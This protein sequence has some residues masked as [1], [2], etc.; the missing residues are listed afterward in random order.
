MSVRQPYRSGSFYEAGP[1]TCR[2]DAQRLL[3]TARVPD[4]L[5]AGIVGGIVPHAGWVYS[6][7][8]AAT[9]LKALDIEHTPEAVVLFGADHFGTASAGEVYDRGAWATPL[10]E[11]A[12]DE[13]L[14]ADI[15]AAGASLT[16]NCPA[17]AQ[18]HSLEVQAPLIQ[19][20]WPQAKLV[21]I[22]VS[23]SA[24]AVE[25]GRCVAGVVKARGGDIVIIGSTDLTHHGGQFGSPGG[26]GKEGVEWTAANDRRMI[27][28]M[29]SMS[30][31]QIVGEAHQRGN[32][33]GAGAI[34]ATI[35]ACSALGATAGWSLAYTNS[36]EVMQALYPGH[37]DDTTVGYAS[38]VFA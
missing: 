22:L 8:V 27:E 33:C 34:A 24:D 28:L 32:A 1:E 2:R 35:A 9:T 3:L 5:P 19:I 16:A 7:L 30:A 31:E 14:A 4:D 20:L 13:P 15:L 11:L 12:I 17:H 26:H 29:E 23:P 6:G 21:P 37:A 38:V 10:G 25:V 36:Y 18:E